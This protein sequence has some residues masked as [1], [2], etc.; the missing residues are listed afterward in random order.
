[1]IAAQIL[2]TVFLG[3]AIFL[4]VGAG[5]GLLVALFRLRFGTALPREQERHLQVMALA[6]GLDPIS[7][8]AGPAPRRPPR[9]ATA[10]PIQPQYFKKSRKT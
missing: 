4:C 6:P 7:G 10:A 9:P 1:L 8:A 3:A 5:T 2:R